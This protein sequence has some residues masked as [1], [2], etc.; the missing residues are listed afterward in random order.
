MDACFLPRISAAEKI[1]GDH[2]LHENY[3]H[4][5]KRPPASSVLSKPAKAAAERTARIRVEGSDPSG[6]GAYPGNT[7]TTD[8]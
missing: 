8:S 5:G 4:R 6:L 3:I 2:M 7:D 1:S